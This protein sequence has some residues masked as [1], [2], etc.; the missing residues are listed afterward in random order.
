MCAWGKLEVIMYCSNCGEKLNDN[1]RVCPSCGTPV[2]GRTYQ[3]AESQSYDQGFSGAAKGA[4]N[5]GPQT[6]R[7]DNTSHKEYNYTGPEYEG[8]YDSG[9]IGWGFLGCCIPLV[10][11]ILFLVWKDN[12]PRSA[13][14]AG[15]G[16]L[17]GVILIVLLNIIA[18]AMGV[19]L[20]ALGLATGMS[21]GDFDL[22][23]LEEFLNENTSTLLDA[24][25]F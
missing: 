1:D 13:K 7:Y 9:S 5:D 6:Y 19:S 21:E 22:S 16:A 3:D 14:A 8:S 17:I 11:L 18:L 2:P 24:L 4:P 12:K 15:I 23:E 10:G 20:G 25:K